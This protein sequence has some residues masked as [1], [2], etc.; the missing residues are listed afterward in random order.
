MT[1]GQDSLSHRV[2]NIDERYGVFRAAKFGVA[3]A[4]GFLVAEGIIIAGLYAIYG[5]TSVP[6]MVYDS[7]LLLG[8]NIAAFVI[9][10]T[11]GFF[12]NEQ[13]TVRDAQPQSSKSSKSLLIRL[14][15]FQGVYAVGNAITIGVQLLLLRAIS[16]NPAIGNII[17]A[18]VAFPISYIFSMKI[19]W[20][21]GL[22]PKN[23]AI[24]KEAKGKPKTI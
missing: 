7:P 19:V 18:I 22:K 9:G 24:G 21:L 8:L 14:L 2:R 4:I 16:L 1:D 5:K 17:G 3:G 13:A 12:V 23:A 11:V 20:R 15:K 10:V 6:G